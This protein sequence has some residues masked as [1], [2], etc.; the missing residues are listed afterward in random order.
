MNDAVWPRAENPRT[1]R[2]DAMLRNSNTGTT[3]SSDVIL[4]RDSQFAGVIGHEEN[5]R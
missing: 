4:H 2:T 3:L 5:P 1:D